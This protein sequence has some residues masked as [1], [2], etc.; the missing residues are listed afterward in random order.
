M[1]PGQ[2]FKNVGTGSIIGEG[3]LL[4][5][6]AHV[7]LNLK[8]DRP[9]QD[10]RVYL[11]PK[12]LTGNLGQDTALRYKVELI[13]YSKALDLALLKISRA[14]SLGEISP[15]SLADSDHTGI[16]ERV[17]AIG[18]PERGGLWTLTTGTISSQIL[19][20]EGIRGK[21]VFQTETSINKGNSGGPLIDRT[22]QVVGINSN[23]ARRGTDGTAITDINFAIKSN[24]VTGWLSSIGYMSKPR[25]AKVIPGLPP[26]SKPEDTGVIPVPSE[27]PKQGKLEDKLRTKK[28]SSREP[29]FSTK[30]RPY[31]HK[32]LF[33]RVEA[34]LEDMMED[35]KTGTRPKK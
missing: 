4:I 32:N 17:V 10:L 33:Q 9:Y 22:G 30:P 23:L 3:G 12:R 25:V 34:E 8:R 21:H 6:T 26:Q 35:M 2:R 29:K 18:H 5:T 27:K 24:V 11:K 13:N 31:T 16:G 20:F 15:L 19:N 14:G 1:D 7:I 28:K